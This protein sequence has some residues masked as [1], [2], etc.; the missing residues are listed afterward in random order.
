VVFC[1]KCGASLIGKLPLETNS[2]E[3]PSDEEKKQIAIDASVLK[4][5]KI[6]SV[7][8]FNEG[9]SLR[10]EIEGNAEP[11][12][13]TPKAE[14]ILGRRDPATGAMPDVDLTPFA[15]YRMGV[16]R[17]HAAIRRDDDNTLNLWDLGSSN[18]T[19]LNGQRLNAHRPYRLHDGDELRLGQMVIRIRFQPAAVPAPEVQ[20]AAEPTPAKPTPKKVPETA[21]LSESDE[22]PEVAAAEPAA[23]KPEPTPAE[24]ATKQPEPSV[25][26]PLVEQQ[27]EPAAAPAQPAPVAGEVKPPAKPPKVSEPVKAQT[28]EQ[29]KPAEAAPEEVKPEEPTVTEDKA[30]EKPKQTEEAKPVAPVEKPAPAAES[31]IPAKTG[32][33]A[34]NT[35][36]PSPSADEQP[37]DDA[38]ADQVQPSESKEQENKTPPDEAGGAR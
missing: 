12:I 7:A 26:G 20:P 1:E 29:P 27:P 16:S 21:P 8:T 2:L 18:G 3:A 35:K 11:V 30:A 17:R 33:E 6:Q 38:K 23:E 31:S 14:A 10:L 25:V 28:T 15:G 5:V 13:L 36:K 19:F 4:K 24:P 9:D 34:K 32:E 22:K 37:Q